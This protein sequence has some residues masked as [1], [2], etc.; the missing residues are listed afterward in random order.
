MFCPKAWELKTPPLTVQATP[1]PAHAMHC[2]NPRRSMPS[3]LWLCLIIFDKFHLRHGRLSSIPLTLPLLDLPPFIPGR[4]GNICRV[5]AV[6]IVKSA[7]SAQVA[8]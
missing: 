3:L 2:R 5:R 6:Y 1:V 7:T 8:S 4:H